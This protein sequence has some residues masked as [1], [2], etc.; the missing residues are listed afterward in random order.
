MKRG[1]SHRA[2]ETTFFEKECGSFK[3][4]SLVC[5]FIGNTS[6]SF[7]LVRLL[8]QWMSDRSENANQQQ[9]QSSQILVIV[10]LP[11]QSTSGTSKD[12]T[13]SLGAQRWKCP[14]KPV[15]P[16][17]ASSSQ[18]WKNV[19]N[20]TGNKSDTAV[21]ITTESQTFGN[22]AQPSRRVMPP[23]C[24]G[25][26]LG[27]PPQAVAATTTKSGGNNEETCI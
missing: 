18:A 25:G 7:L 20:R 9:D 22:N 1:A 26:A 13:R 16:P 3:Q 12:T 2:N 24:Q 4:P 15:F 27:A 14:R 23:V 6:L 10:L 11:F 17:V 8:M 5:V 21:L 19:T